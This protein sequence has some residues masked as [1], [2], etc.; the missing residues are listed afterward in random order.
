MSEE[1][2]AFNTRIKEHAYKESWQTDK[3][4]VLKSVILV[5]HV[6][7]VVEAA[8]QEFPMAT[9]GDNLLKAED[10]RKLLKERH[11]WFVRWFGGEKE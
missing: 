6:E 8:K 9:Y 11:E 5:D 7:K 2:G 4:T 1:E 3:M 10:C